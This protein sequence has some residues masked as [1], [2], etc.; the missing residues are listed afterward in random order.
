MGHALRYIAT[1]PNSLNVAQ[2]DAGNIG[3]LHDADDLRGVVVDNRKH[4]QVALN[5]SLAGAVEG[6]V[7]PQRDNIVAHQVGCQ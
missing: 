5:A 7:C 2:V 1:R 4:Q 3:A 6:V